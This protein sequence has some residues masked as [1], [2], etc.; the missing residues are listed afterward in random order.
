MIK[1]FTVILDANLSP[2]FLNKQNA[3]AIFE[4][5]SSNIGVVYLYASNNLGKKFL[6]LKKCLRFFFP[7]NDIHFW[8]NNFQGDN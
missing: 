5:C 3:S 2:A 4:R 7:L 6:P 1:W 8:G